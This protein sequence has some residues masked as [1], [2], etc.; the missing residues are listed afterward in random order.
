MIHIFNRQFRGKLIKNMIRVLMQP[1]TFVDV[2]MPQV[3]EYLI[4]GHSFTNGIK[5]SNKVFVCKGAS[6]LLFNE[7]P[8]EKISISSK[9]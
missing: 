2:F 7:D 6:Y 5:T 4:P 9:A 8:L 1:L 3:S